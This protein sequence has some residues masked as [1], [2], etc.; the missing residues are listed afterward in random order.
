MLSISPAT[1]SKHGVRHPK[2]HHRVHRRHGHS[3]RFLLAQKLAHGLR[4]TPLARFAFVFEA[5]GHRWNVNP[6]LVAAISGTESSF[7]A[8][9]CGYNAWGLASCDG[10][11][12]LSSFQDGIRY[13][14]RLLR[15]NYLNAGDTSVLSVGYKYAACG[16]CWAAKTEGFMVQLGAT[17]FDTAYR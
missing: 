14:T 4:G 10:S 12:S 5:A 13:T 2:K 8:A 17:G 16:S 1:A 15:L 11:V 7:G 3:P 6:F 9:A